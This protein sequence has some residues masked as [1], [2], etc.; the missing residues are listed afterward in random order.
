M[1]K[2]QA[3]EYRHF[4]YDERN[5]QRHSWWNSNAGPDT[6]T[7]YDAA[8][9]VTA[10][11]DADAYI[12]FGYDAANRKTSE[13]ETITSYGLYQTHTVTYEYD[14]DGNRSRLVYPKGFDY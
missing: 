5:R 3:E 6:V 11:Y 10:M 13:T 14:Q 7:E 4:S 2:T 8:S 12:G 1:Y 9:R